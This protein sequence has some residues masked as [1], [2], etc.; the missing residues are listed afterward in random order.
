MPFEAARTRSQIQPKARLFIDWLGLVVWSVWHACVDG[1]MDGWM[2][3]GVWVVGCWFVEIDCSIFLPH[4]TT[5]TTTTTTPSQD[6]VV[7]LPVGARLANGASTLI[8]LLA[9]ASPSGASQTNG[10][11][12]GRK[13][14]RGGCLRGVLDGWMDGWMDWLIKWLI[15][16]NGW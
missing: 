5:T 8:T 16:L 2:D 10:F 12:N 6:T 3:G 9:H 7:T 13:K 15:E 14:G 4:T 1:W 11:G